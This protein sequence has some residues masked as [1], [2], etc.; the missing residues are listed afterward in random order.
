MYI[1]SSQTYLEQNRS[2]KFIDIEE[3]ARTLYDDNNEYQ[4]NI[5]VFFRVVDPDPD[6][7]RNQ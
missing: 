2:K 7:I 5:F 1:F 6:W 3:M 4:V